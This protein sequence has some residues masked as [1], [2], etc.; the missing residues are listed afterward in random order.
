MADTPEHF[1]HLVV[2]GLPLA[3]AEIYRRAV[4]LQGLIAGILI[5][6]AVLVLARGIIR[7][8]RIRANAMHRTV[9]PAH[10]PQLGSQGVVP[11]AKLD[12]QRN[13]STNVVETAKLSFDESLDGLRSAVRSALSAIV[14]QGGDAFDSAARRYC[15]RVASFA[16]D[17]PGVRSILDE[18]TAA[19]LA[20]LESEIASIKAE[21]AAVSPDLESIK[22]RLVRINACARTIQ[23]SRGEA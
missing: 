16:I 13:D 17:C 11:S 4:E 19:G 8:A 22:Q 12:F 14:A 10:E 15:E 2:K 23:Q 1:G 20:A 9:A 18:S 7:S 6:V 21:V 3:F 5:L